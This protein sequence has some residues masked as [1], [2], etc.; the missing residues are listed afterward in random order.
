SWRS[1]CLGGYGGGF[2]WAAGNAPPLCGAI[3]WT[4]MRLESTPG[5]RPF[6]HLALSVGFQFARVGVEQ[7]DALAQLFHGHRV[8]VVH[9]AIGLL[10][11]MNRRNVETLGANRVERARNLALAPGELREQVGTDG[12]QIRSS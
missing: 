10:V 1:D 12:Q 9:P 11:E 4:P 2:G 5:R 7:A 8:L 6:S 3:V